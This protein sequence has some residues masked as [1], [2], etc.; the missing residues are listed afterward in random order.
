[1][2]NYIQPGNTIPLTAP[3]DVVGGDGLLVGSIFGVAAHPATTGN[4]VETG[5][6]GVYEITALGTDDIAVGDRLYWDN[7]NKRLTKVASTHKLVG[8]AVAAS[9]VGVTTVECRLSAAFTL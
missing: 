5:L 3:Y 2:Q 1:M 8:V 9:G 4:E 6:V 7:T